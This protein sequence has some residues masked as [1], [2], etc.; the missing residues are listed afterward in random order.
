MPRKAN[1]PHPK[2]A[3]TQP[4]WRGEE[5]D[6]FPEPAPDKPVE[7]KHTKALEPPPDPSETVPPGVQ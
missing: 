7:P 3:P 1:K 4:W 2:P 6:L 5:P